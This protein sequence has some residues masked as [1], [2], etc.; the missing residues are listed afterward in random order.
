MKRKNLQ[1]FRRLFLFLL[2]AGFVIFGAVPSAFAGLTTFTPTDNATNVC[3]DVVITMNFSPGIDSSFL[4]GTTFS[5]NGVL[6]GNNGTFTVTNGTASNA[7]QI[8]FT[9]GS[10]LVSNT[11]TSYTWQ[12]S[13]SGVNFG[14]FTFT[15]GSVSSTTGTCIDGPVSVGLS[16]T[17]TV[18]LDSAT[19]VDPNVQ[20][21]AT[22]SEAVT[23][24]SIQSA[25]TLAT[26]TGTPVNGTV[27]LDST[28]KVATFAPSQALSTQTSY[29]ATVS[30]TVAAANGDTLSASKT[31]SFTTGTVD[32]QHS[33]TKCFIATAAYGSYLEPH[34][35]VLRAFR[36]KYLLTNAP[37]RAFVSFYY[38]NSP[39]LAD[40]ISRHGTLR[41]ITRWALTPLVYTAEY[42]VSLPVSLAFFFVFGIIFV[43]KRK[44]H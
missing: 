42:P 44:R 6:V 28:G 19:D 36:D 12:N 21:S 14:P 30:T 25:F 13:G 40:F 29:T 31:W 16:V 10:A 15:T 38:R 18:P 37:G 2:L 17:S 33:G 5:I 24:T 35:V 9:P 43:V 39:P 34:V 3:T 1:P 32:F 27:T 8:T 11:L 7:T 22:F 26:T 20:P 41:M 23:L 4:S